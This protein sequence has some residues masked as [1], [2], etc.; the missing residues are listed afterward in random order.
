LFERQG[1]SLVRSRRVPRQTRESVLPEAGR[2]V[3]ALP[4]LPKGIA[5]GRATGRSVR[6][7]LLCLSPQTG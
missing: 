5:A 1:H 2:H 4:S 3:L 7:D 6:N